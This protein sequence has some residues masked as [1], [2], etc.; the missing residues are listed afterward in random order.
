MQIERSHALVK[1]TGGPARGRIRDGAAR[2]MGIPFAAAPVGP[3]RF[4]L[5]REPDW[6]TR[7]WDATVP[8]ATPLRPEVATEATLIP[9]PAYGGDWTLNASVFSPA[10]PHP[11]LAPVLVWIHGGGFVSGSPASPWYDGTAFAQAGVVTVNLSY[12]LGMEGFG[13]LEGAP[14]NRGFWDWIAGLQWVRRNIAAFG[15]DPE[16]V[17]IAGQS[18]GGGAVLTLMASPHGAG[19]FS[20]AIALSPALADVPP[21]VA[22]EAAQRVARDLG[23]EPTAVDMANFDAAKVEYARAQIDRSYWRSSSFLAQRFVDPGV[24]YGPMVDGDALASSSVSGDSLGR[25]LDIPLFIGATNGEMN[26]IFDD[27]PDL[28]HADP[29]EL[30]LSCGVDS[31]EAR[32]RADGG[33][34]AARVL[35]AFITD[36]VFRATAHEV[37]HRR[38]DLGADTWLYEFATRG[39]EEGGSA[40]CSDVPY[41]FAFGPVTEPHA[42]GSSELF[43]DTVRFVTTHD[44]AWPTFDAEL[45]CT[46]VYAQPAR[47][48]FDHDWPDYARLPQR[49]SSNLRL[50]HE[51]REGTDGHGY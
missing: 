13:A 25:S 29:Y 46:K 19:L 37:A 49:P 33:A 26:T 17:T 2:F 18:A 10:D 16:R 36:V 35:G 44:A 20:A 22:R 5:P 31:A 15:G 32:R 8:P 21:S 39:V 4:A 28:E 38:A 1:T 7:I 48:A 23:A 47:L 45:A 34:G 42:E 40:H 43:W 6:G 12:R 9:E 11:S 14:N 24:E 51:P 3:D 30:L 41:F 27:A 50:P